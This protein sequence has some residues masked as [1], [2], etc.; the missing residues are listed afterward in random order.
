MGFTFTIRR[1]LDLFLAHLWR[2]SDPGLEYL[3]NAVLLSGYRA[4]LLSTLDHARAAISKFP[5][6]DGRNS[7]PLLYHRTI[8]SPHTG[9]VRVLW[10]AK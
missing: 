4:E 2:A 10:A 6:I 9:F 7:F 1:F 3:A 8:A 5:A